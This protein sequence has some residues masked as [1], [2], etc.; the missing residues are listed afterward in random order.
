M[1]VFVFS[2]IVGEFLFIYLFSSFD[3]VYLI[4]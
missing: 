3:R 4:F 2:V 1:D